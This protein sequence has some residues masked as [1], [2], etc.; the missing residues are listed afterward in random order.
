MASD[1]FTDD[2][3]TGLEV[4]DANWTSIDATHVVTNI[5]I[6]SN[7]AE[8]EG[9]YKRFGAYYDGSAEDTSQILKKAFNSS[10][11]QGPTTRADTDELGYSIMLTGG[12][13]GNWTVIQVNKSGNYLGDT[14]SVSYAQASDHT[15]KITVSGTTTVTIDY[16]IDGDAI[17]QKSDSSSPLGAGHP[18]FW[19]HYAGEDITCTQFDDWTD[20]AAAG[21]IS[22]PVVMLQHDHFNGGAML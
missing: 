19:S 21:G 14:G 18:G 5:E 1:A 3:G 2:D 17:G 15:M 9:N 7:L 8:A 4:H 13:G 6:N 16:W 11:G 10:D 12:S 22:I 20:G